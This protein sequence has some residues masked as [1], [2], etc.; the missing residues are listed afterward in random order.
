MIED[1]KALAAEL[2][3]PHV[4]VEPYHTWNNRNKKRREY[5]T[6]VPGLAEQ[7]YEAAVD[8]RRVPDEAGGSNPNKP[9][10]RPPLGLEAFGRWMEIL[11]GV[12]GWCLTLGLGDRL[13]VENG[14][15]AIKQKAEDLGQDAIQA[16]VQDM[17]TWRRWCVVMTGW[18]TKVF[19]PAVLC[20]SCESWR[21]VRIRCDIGEGFCSE[22]QHS[23]TTLDDLVSFGKTAQNAAA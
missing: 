18:E 12:K 15:L 17:K 5:R 13:T 3:E 23:W 10:S 9:E 20:P 6:F 11:Q 22:C 4:H 16:I 7:L 1:L 21:S 19:T 14:I 8:P 2:A